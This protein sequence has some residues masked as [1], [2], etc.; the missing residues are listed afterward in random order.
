M[1]GFRKQSF[2]HKTSSEEFKEGIREGSQVSWSSICQEIHFLR[3]FYLPEGW[4]QEP[5]SVTKDRKIFL[6]AVLY[7]EKHLQCMSL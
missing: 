7:A 1:C 3:T 4:S 2:H 5:C 6:S